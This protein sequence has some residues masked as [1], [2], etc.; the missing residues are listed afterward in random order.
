MEISIKKLKGTKVYFENDTEA[1]GVV[2]DVIFDCKL[3][4]A[5]ALVIKTI[6]LIPFCRLIGMEYILSLYD[7]KIVLKRTCNPKGLFLE[8]SGSSILNQVI[9]P[10]LR[11][12]RLKDI[13]FDF[14]TGLLCDVVFSKNIL[15]GNHKVLINKISLKDNTIYIEN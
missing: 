4:K 1:W 15:S 13:H 12:S 2:S 8:T 14:E 6:S 11:K 9:D 7:K 10:N 3:K 5:V